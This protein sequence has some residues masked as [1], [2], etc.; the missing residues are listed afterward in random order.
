[1][2]EFMDCEK[3]TG[4]QLTESLAMHPAA[5]VSGLYFSHPQSTYF[6][7]GKIC[8]DQVGS[9]DVILIDFDE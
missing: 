4:I 1:M 7:V 2:W 9:L 5:S 3:L 6:A 8:E